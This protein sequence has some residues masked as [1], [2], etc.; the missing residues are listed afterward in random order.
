VLIISA[1]DHVLNAPTFGSVIEIMIQE[2]AHR[3]IFHGHAPIPRTL[4][5]LE[6]LRGGG[7]SY[8]QVR[9]PARSNKTPSDSTNEHD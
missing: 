5:K 1:A 4:P 2:N 6:T 8:H 3:A 7:L 9:G